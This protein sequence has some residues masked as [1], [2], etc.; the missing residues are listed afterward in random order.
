MG[1]LKRALKTLTKSLR[2]PCDLLGGLDRQSPLPKLREGVLGVRSPLWPLNCCSFIPAGRCGR[3]R[4]P[5]GRSQRIRHFC[6]SD[7][8]ERRGGRG[9]GG[10]QGWDRAED[11]ARDSG[12]SGKGLRV[13]PGAVLGT[14][15]CSR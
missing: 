2:S 7:F 1:T 13:M 14:G 6:Q 4:P 3:C 9:S 10:F 8:G 5:K 12:R 15:M 11:T